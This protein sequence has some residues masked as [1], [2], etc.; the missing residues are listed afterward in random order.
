MV[1][2]PEH[3]NLSKEQST[4][5]IDSMESFFLDNPIKKHTLL[6]LYLWNQIKYFLPFGMVIYKLEL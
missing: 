4:I 5:C 3:N 2:E 6:F 1:P